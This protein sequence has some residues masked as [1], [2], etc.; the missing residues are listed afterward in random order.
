MSSEE[1]KIKL[2]NLL[3]E[4]VTLALFEQMQAGQ[5]QQP[6]PPA[7][8]T[9]PPPQN[10]PTNAPAASPEEQA[11]QNQPYPQEELTLDT[12]IERLNVIRGGKSF[13]DPEI[14]GQLTTYF[15]TL[16]PESKSMLDSFLQNVSKIMVNV[17]QNPEEGNSPETNPG[18]AG[19]QNTPPP[20]TSGMP[21]TGT[22]PQTMGGNSTA[23]V[24]P[25][26]GMSPGGI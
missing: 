2:E 14:Y 5:M 7:V 9:P 1:K 19:A 20:P 8:P 21:P 12:M 11:P 6:P 10:P 15:K 17:R 22:S 24:S 13:T 18:N 16:T 23:P 4:M 3:K 26:G 25:V